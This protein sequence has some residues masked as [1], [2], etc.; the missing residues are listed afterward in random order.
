MLCSY[1][2]HYSHLSWTK[3][4][5][6]LMKT[7]HENINNSNKNKLR[8][9]VSLNSLYE[10]HKYLR[11]DHRLVGWVSCGKTCPPGFKFSTWHGCSYFSEFILGFN[12]ATLSVVGDVPVDSKTSVVTSSISKFVGSILRRS[13]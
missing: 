7:F 8:Y 11:I 1:D 12:G 13:S 5:S 3:T 10:T 6:L 9:V 2:F 4:L